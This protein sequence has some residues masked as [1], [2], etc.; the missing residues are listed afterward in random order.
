M[1]S[2]LTYWAYPYKSNKKWTTIYKVWVDDVWDEAT[3]EIE[4][5]V[6]AYPPLTWKYLPIGED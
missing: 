1:K 3:Y 6:K 4:E 2:K 5:F